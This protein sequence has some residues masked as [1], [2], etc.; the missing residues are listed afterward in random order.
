MVLIDTYLRDNL[1]DEQKIFNNFTDSK[2]TYHN[3]S[4]S[5]SDID[6]IKSIYISKINYFLSVN[7]NRDC[8]KD[9]Y[10]KYYN[11]EC[12]KDNQRH[13]K[14]EIIDNI[15]FIKAYTNQA[16]EKYNSQNCI[17]LNFANS[18]GIAGSYVH[19]YYKAQEESL[20][21]VIYNLYYSLLCLDTY[22]KKDA[23][24][25]K[26]EEINN[27]EVYKYKYQSKLYNFRMHGIIYTKDLDLYRKDLL[28]ENPGT[29]KANT[30]IYPKLAK[31]IKVSIITAAAPDLRWID[32]YEYKE[33][34]EYKD[35]YK[36]VKAS[37]YRILEKM[38]YTVCT[39][40]ISKK[41]EILILGAIGCGAF[42]PPG[43]KDF[44]ANQVATIIFD[45]IIDYKFY[46]KIKIVFAI[47]ITSE[48]DKNFN[49]FQDVFNKKK[50]S[51]KYSECIKY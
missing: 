42:T 13:H 32:R 7:Q 41:Y 24:R 25:E 1:S 15:I 23:V 17:A 40:A 5:L 9:E 44:Y 36:N 35:D 49:I 20:C 50:A 12:I 38:I 33:F 45:I 3:I 6:T 51:I 48:T 2:E 10:I 8:S 11:L 22:F 30:N 37:I 4:Y 43:Y 46:K 27:I 34:M 14:Q 47:P 18:K 26:P 39:I 21:L 31:P 29:I 16:I 19:G 28:K